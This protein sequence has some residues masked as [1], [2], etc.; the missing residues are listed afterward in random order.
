VQVKIADLAR[1]RNGAF[2]K[3]C[4]PHLTP[5]ERE[6]L[7]SGICGECWDAMFPHDAEEDE[8]DE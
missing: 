2:A 1:F 6:F 3:D 5:A 7:I 4:F 8:T